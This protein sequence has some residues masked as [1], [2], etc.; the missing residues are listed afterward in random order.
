[1][2]VGGGVGRLPVSPA[3]EEEEEEPQEGVKGN[4]YYGMLGIKDI[5]AESTEAW[6][7][8]LVT[9]NQNVVLEVLLSSS[10]L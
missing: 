3:E 9:M 7:T 1:M 8:V 4:I 5:S 2:C 6:V 10:V